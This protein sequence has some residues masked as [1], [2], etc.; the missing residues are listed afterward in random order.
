MVRFVDDIVVV[1]ENEDDL[2]CLLEKM[3]KIMGQEYNMKNN[4]SKTKVMLCDRD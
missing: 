2:K 3:K 4:K 1:A